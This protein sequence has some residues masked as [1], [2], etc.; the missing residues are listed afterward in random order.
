M[1]GENRFDLGLF[2][3]GESREATF[4]RPGIVRVYC[5]V[6]ER[7]AAT[8]VVTPNG[9]AARVREDGT[10]EIR[11][12]PPGK[13]KLRIW[14]ERGGEAT[15]DVD[16]SEAGNVDTKLELDARGYRKTSHLDK[17]GKRYSDRIEPL[18]YE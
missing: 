3:K 2:G 11:D 6:H 8:I 9:H 17:D 5:N 1:S 16:V 14:D 10:F 7:M 4:R 15:S 12:V 13:H 18:P